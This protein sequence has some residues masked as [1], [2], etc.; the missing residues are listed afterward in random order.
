MT[1]TSLIVGCL[2]A[3]LVGGGEGVERG[4]I[5]PTAGKQEGLM[6]RL[7]HSERLIADGMPVG[8]FGELFKEIEAVKHRG[9]ESEDNQNKVSEFAKLEPA[10]RDDV[11]TA[12][13]RDQG[14]ILVDACEMEFKSY[15]LRQKVFGNYTDKSMTDKDIKSAFT[16]DR[17][18][19]ELICSC[20]H[21]ASSMF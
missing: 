4:R 13:Q 15:I 2:V 9:W 1:G 12:E 11:I 20:W 6:K 18:S 14:R 8:K 16:I 21:C 19:K 17:K 5:A 10:N 3:V 7:L